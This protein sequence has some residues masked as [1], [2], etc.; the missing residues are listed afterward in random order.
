MMGEMKHDRK[1]NGIK[2]LRGQHV[3]AGTALAVAIA[4]FPGCASYSQDPVIVGSVPDDYRTRHPIIVS[5]S[6]RSADIVVPIRAYR[7]S[8]RARDT[9]REMGYKFKTSGA[10]SL[11]ILIPSGS[12]NQAAARRLAR[13]AVG[14]LSRLRIG[15]DRIVIEHYD[16]AAHG[17]AA[18]LRLAYTDLVASVP[19]G[20]G[21][22]N[23]DL[24]ATAD[25]RNYYNFGCA[26]QNNLAQM[27]ANPADLLGPRGMS[28]IDSTRRTNVIDTWRKKGSA[29]SLETGSFEKSG[30]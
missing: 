29:G 24:L 17:D 19:S 21:D 22:W 14:E 2:S 26:T 7:L 11:A 3:L 27:I 30:D 28:E 4:V 1:T 25:N 12:A 16:A 6:E 13:D 20:C 10:R 9:V 15:H 5:E 23:E 18:T 8:A